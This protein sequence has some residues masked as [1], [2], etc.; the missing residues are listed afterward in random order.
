MSCSFALSLSGV[1]FGRT[2]PINDD[3]E[4]ML[5]RTN[6]RKIRYANN[7]TE[8]DQ[9][10][11]DSGN[12][13]F[14]NAHLI[15]GIQN[16]GSAPSNWSVALDATIGWDG[17]TVDKDYYSFFMMGSGVVQVTL[18]NIPESCDYDIEI[19]G[20]D[21]TA[22]FS[23][24]NLIFLNHSVNGG[25]KVDSLSQDAGAGLYY[26]CVMSKYNQSHD[27]S[28][29]YHL[30]VNGSYSSHPSYEINRLYYD[31][32]AKGAVWI[33]DFNPAE[34]KP[35]SSHGTKQ[36]GWQSYFLGAANWMQLGLTS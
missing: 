30:V 36:Y 24:S 22:Y 32:G 1:A 27:D 26:V 5:V 3:Q 11:G 8:R 35:F 12:N 33:S 10:E 28:S 25:Q 34:I 29:C 15:Q 17:S 21:D 16:N 6:G 4:K 13:S 2:S 20:A 14:E 31:K 18:S 23:E 9:Y 19:W 7:G